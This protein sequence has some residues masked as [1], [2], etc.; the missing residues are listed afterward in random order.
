MNTLTLLIQSDQRSSPASN[1]PPPPP[2][3]TWQLDTCVSYIS[4]IMLN[5][6]HYDINS[7]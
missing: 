2:V 1:P 7:A 3:C 5:L 6:A 4:H